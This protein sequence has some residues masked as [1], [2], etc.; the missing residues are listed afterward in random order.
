[1]ED[2]D[3]LDEKLGHTE[4]TLRHVR[5]KTNEKR[6]KGATPKEKKVL[7]EA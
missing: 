4:Q 3:V 1:M 2:R 6:D 5:N 7:G